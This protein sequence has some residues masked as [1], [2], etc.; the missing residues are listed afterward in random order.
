PR[1]CPIPN[2]FFTNVL[3]RAVT[4]GAHVFSVASNPMG[5]IRMESGYV[6]QLV[7]GRWPNRPCIVHVT[8][9]GRSLLQH[10]SHLMALYDSGLRNLL[11]I[12]GD[13][14]TNCPNSSPITDMDS[15]QFIQLIK[16]R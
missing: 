7:Q 11:I 5:T 6:A 1:T 12:N 4:N 9:T 16:Q 13:S 14:P 8:C 10:Q 3:D 2:N 15:I